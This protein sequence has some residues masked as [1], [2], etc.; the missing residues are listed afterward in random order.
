MAG[1]ECGRAR[2]SS[3]YLYASLSPVSAL[4]PCG[5]P[6]SH[7]AY[8][9]S[10]V[11]DRPRVHAVRALCVKVQPHVELSVRPIVTRALVHQS[12]VKH[13]NVPCPQPDGAAVLFPDF[14]GIEA[15]GPQMQTPFL[16]RLRR[17][18]IGN[19]SCFVRASFSLCAKIARGRPA[20]CVRA[21]RPTVKLL[22][23]SVHY[24]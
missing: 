21:P 8:A 18:P 23:T 9:L 16:C 7:Q 5:A 13:E 15:R 17:T 20:S 24:G 2:Y 4:L 6:R 22:C 10:F 3:A 14:R 1:T 12:A 19:P 11:A